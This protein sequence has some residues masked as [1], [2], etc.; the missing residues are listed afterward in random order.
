MDVSDRLVYVV[1]QKGASFMAKVRKKTAKPKRP[2]RKK[3]S[4]ARR[5][6]PGGKARKPAR[7]TAARRKVARK[8][9]ASPP[10]PNPLRQ[11][12]QRIVDLTVNQDDESSFALYADNVESVEPG[13]PPTTGMDAIRQKFAM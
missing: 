9:A 10:R 6:R 7:A 12:A 11:L 5:P 13:M 2:A 8:P 3:G 1:K 4:A